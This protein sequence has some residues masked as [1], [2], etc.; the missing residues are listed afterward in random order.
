MFFILAVMTPAA[1]R[2]RCQGLYVCGPAVDPAGMCF[3]MFST[4]CKQV[5]VLPA[6]CD[7][8]WS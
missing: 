2:G 3:Q 5:D 8:C 7:C 4:W 1:S 6:G